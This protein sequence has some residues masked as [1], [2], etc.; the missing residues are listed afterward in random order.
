[1]TNRFPWGSGPAPAH[2]CREC[3]HRIGKRRFHCIV[4]D[5]RVLCAKCLNQRPLHAKY[6][7]GCPDTW[8]D[9]HD[10]GTRF[11]TRAAAWFVLAQRTNT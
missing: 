1:M 7:P 9:M 5:T 10:H 8:H 11:A 4:A 3:G 6:Y 2:D